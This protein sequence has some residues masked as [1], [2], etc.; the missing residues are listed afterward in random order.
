MITILYLAH[1]G[2]VQALALQSVISEARLVRDPLLVDLLVKSGQDTHNLCATRVDADVATH[3]IVHV[4]R[5][6]VLQLPRAS[7]E[8]ERLYEHEQDDA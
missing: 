3:C 2:R 5:L 1:H 8:S 4:H 6:G 7:G